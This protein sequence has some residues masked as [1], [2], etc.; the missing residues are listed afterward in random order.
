MAKKKPNPTA[1]Q[2]VKDA[3]LFKSYIELPDMGPQCSCGMEQICNLHGF[4]P[5]SLCGKNLAEWLMSENK[6]DF[7]TE[8]H[9]MCGCQVL[10]KGILTV[11]ETGYTISEMEEVEN[12][13]PRYH[14][15]L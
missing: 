15:G 13:G 12:P 14:R 2:E 11:T 10:H 6:R 8:V 3:I 5:S 9:G 1:V 4:F 7:T